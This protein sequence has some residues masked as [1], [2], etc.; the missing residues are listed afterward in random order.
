MLGLIV[1]ALITG[2]KTRVPNVDYFR[3]P[4]QFRVAS[5]QHWDAM[6]QMEAKDLTTRVSADGQTKIL[7]G[8]G[9]AVSI[10]AAEQTDF[11]RCY[12]KMLQ[13]ELLTRGVRIAESPEQAPMRCLVETYVVTHG[14]VGT[15]SLFKYYLKHPLGFF[16][17]KRMEYENPSTSFWTTVANAAQ[18]MIFGGE[19][20]DPRGRIE[21]LV[22]TTVF[23][24]NQPF[25][26]YKQI[27]YLGH[28]SELQNYMKSEPD[29]RW[30]V[31]PMNEE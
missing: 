23:R 2:C 5:M 28:E 30:V 18:F 21:M 25:A 7:G 29:I 1:A 27:V 9:P 20:G 4:S 13:T 12:T 14:S 24:G 3:G 10:Q 15:A 19:Y 11:T 31:R 22:L 26:A 16:Y 6:A 17:C 8:Q